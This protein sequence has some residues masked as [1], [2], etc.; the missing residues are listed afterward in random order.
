MSSR[1]RAVP[2]CLLFPAQPSRA[3]ADQ[4]QKYRVNRGF[5]T[6][7]SGR[8]DNKRRR[9]QQK[10]AGID[11]TPGIAEARQHWGSREAKKSPLGAVWV[12][13]AEG[14]EAMQS[15]AQHR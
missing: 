5:S 12:A 13:P 4:A 7:L 14:K 8:P 11:I 9:D 2:P 3:S 15:S 10:S 1:F 6:I